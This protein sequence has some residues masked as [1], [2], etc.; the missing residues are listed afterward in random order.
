MNLLLH[1]LHRPSE[2]ESVY[3]AYSFTNPE[4]LKPGPVHH[5]IEKLLIGAEFF[6]PNRLGVPALDG[7][8]AATEADS[9][10]HEYEGIEETEDEAQDSRSMREFL[11]E[12][13]K[14]KKE[15]P[16]EFW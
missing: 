13:K 16:G 6:V 2:T 3:G 15:N 9:D 10:Y 14:Y 4:G 1:Y 8:T 11:D 12:L 5:E 7:T